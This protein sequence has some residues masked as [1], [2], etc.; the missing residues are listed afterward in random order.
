MRLRA[1]FTDAEDI[2]EGDIVDAFFVISSQ[3]I[4]M[5]Y[6]APHGGKIDHFYYDVDELLNDWEV[7]KEDADVLAGRYID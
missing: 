7:P 2:N 4:K 3:V 6:Y 5:S 1:K